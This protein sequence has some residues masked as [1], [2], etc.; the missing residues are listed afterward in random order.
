LSEELG[1]PPPRH[2]GQV[3]IGDP[4]ITGQEELIENLIAG[5]PLLRRRHIPDKSIA[6]KFL[7]KDE[8][9]GGDALL[10]F[11]EL[12][13]RALQVRFGRAALQ[14]WPVA[15]AVELEIELDAVASEGTDATRNG[16]AARGAP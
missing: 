1:G 8:A 5:S 10:D 2:E 4:R 9:A 11:L 6:R 3:F 13:A 14:G 7:C 15:H 16:F 12:L